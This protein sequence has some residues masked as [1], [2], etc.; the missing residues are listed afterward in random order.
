MLKKPRN[1]KKI[2]NFYQTYLQNELWIQKYCIILFYSSSLRR[3]IY[4]KWAY[5]IS[6][7]NT[8]PEIKVLGVFVAW[9]GEKY[10]F[11]KNVN[12]VFRCSKTCEKKKTQRDLKCARF[13]AG[14]LARCVSVIWLVWLLVFFSWPVLSHQL[15]CVE[16]SERAG[17]LWLCKRLSCST[18]GICQ[19]SRGL[20]G[21]QHC[22]YWSV[23]Q[24]H[25][26]QTIV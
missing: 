2:G 11:E 23:P 7:Q 10:G 8:L 1:E 22:H 21:C 15:T 14:S 18:L 26:R 19:L 13:I 9:A 5:K 4:W 16:H 6:V 12:Q 17:G 3:S 25:A 24:H 20:P